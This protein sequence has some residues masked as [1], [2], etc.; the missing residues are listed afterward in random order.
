MS[1]SDARDK[2]QKETKVGRGDCYFGGGFVIIH[3]LFT[4]HR[5]EEVATPG[6]SAWGRENAC[7]GTFE[8]QRARVLSR[9][10]ETKSRHAVKRDG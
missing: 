6:R 10:R 5:Q 7:L 3:R 9:V 8:L 2:E 1:R 4:E